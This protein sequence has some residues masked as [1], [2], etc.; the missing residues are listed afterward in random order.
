M[1]HWSQTIEHQLNGFTPYI[2]LPC[3]TSDA[4]GS[5]HWWKVSSLVIA[6]I[7][8]NRARAIV[9]HHNE[10]EHPVFPCRYLQ[11][12]ELCTLKPIFLTI[13]L[14]RPNSVKLILSVSTVHCFLLFA[15]TAIVNVF[16]CPINCGEQNKM[17]F[18][19]NWLNLRISCTWLIC[20]AIRNIHSLVCLSHQWFE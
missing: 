14:H 20:I 12:R 13:T 11:K 2:F 5:V 4:D 16:N 18:Y 9:W 3:R 19:H 1:E 10:E 7:L 17:N 6:C 8:K 15:R